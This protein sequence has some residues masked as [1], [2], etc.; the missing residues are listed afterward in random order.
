MRRRAYIFPH[1][2]ASGPVA[3][4]LLTSINGFSSGHGILT[5]A[6]AR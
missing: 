2:F 5:E 1:R 4:N 3:T 6:A